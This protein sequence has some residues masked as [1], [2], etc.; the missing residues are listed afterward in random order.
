VF[1]VSVGIVRAMVGTVFHTQNTTYVK[2]GGHQI[3]MLTTGCKRVI[4]LLNYVT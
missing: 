4:T 3:G 1:T 2:N